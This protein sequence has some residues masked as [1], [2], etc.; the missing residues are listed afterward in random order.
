MSGY[1]NHNGSDS[2][3][4]DFNPAPMVDEDDVEEVATN[5]NAK[6]KLSDAQDN[7]DDNERGP[8]RGQEG[9]D[10]EDEDDGPGGDE[11]DDEEDEDDDDE[12]DEDVVVS[13]NFLFASELG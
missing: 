7:E 12:D 13:H 4:E 2:E 10:E 1:D 3:E 9:D 11:E 5:G 8:T 6:Q